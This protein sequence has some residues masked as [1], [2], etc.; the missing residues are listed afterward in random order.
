MDAR[1]WHIGG[2]IASSLALAPKWGQSK[3]RVLIFKKKVVLACFYIE[4]NKN[5][6]RTLKKMLCAL[7]TLRNAAVNKNF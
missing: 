5:Y 3:E 2:T 6:T 1:F 4:R 7:Y